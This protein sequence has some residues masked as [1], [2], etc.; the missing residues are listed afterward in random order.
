MQVVSNDTLGFRQREIANEMCAEARKKIAA[1]SSRKEAPYI[2]RVLLE[3]D[4]KSIAAPVDVTLRPGP[5]GFRWLGEPDNHTR[6]LF[7]KTVSMKDDEPFSIVS[8][9]ILPDHSAEINQ[10]I[11][12]P[13]GEIGSNVRARPELAALNALLREFIR[14]AQSIGVSLFRFKPDS[15]IPHPSAVREMLLDE[16]FKYRDRAITLKAG[17]LDLKA[18]AS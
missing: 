7:V 8:G 1:L 10:V 11:T 6:D 2:R 4:G 9:K 17:D 18:I 3:D 5:K 14:V 15:N 16:G 12:S 13:P